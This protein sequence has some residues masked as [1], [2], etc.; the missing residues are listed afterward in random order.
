MLILLRE[1][2]KK[3]NIVDLIEE[4]REMIICKWGYIQANRLF[5]EGDSTQD[6]QNQSIY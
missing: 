5:Q 2:W 1:M 4:Y 6:D 3:N